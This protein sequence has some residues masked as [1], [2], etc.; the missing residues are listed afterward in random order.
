MNEMFNLACWNIHGFKIEKLKNEYFY[1]KFHIFGITETWTNKESN[2]ILPG[3]KAIAS[4]G[5]KRNHKKGRRS[6]G[7]IIYVKDD[8]FNQ[9]A[10]QL[11]KTSLMEKSCLNP[12][13]SS[14]ESV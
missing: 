9:H 12:S 7:I 3:Y 4:H 5:T 6:G 14:S 13:E 2:I 1:E 10:V 8:L 11:V